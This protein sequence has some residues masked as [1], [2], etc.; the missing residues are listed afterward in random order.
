MVKVLIY[1]AGAIGSFLAYLL[2][3]GDEVN[4]AVDD[5][6]LLGRPG[7]MQE[8]GES[9]LQIKSSEGIKTIYFRHCFSQLNELSSS[10]FFPEVVVLCVKTH[11]LAAVSQEIEQSGLAGG[12]LK[13][14]EFILLMNGMGNRERIDLPS[15]QVFEGI[16]SIGVV[17]SEGGKIELKGRGK[18]IIESGIS[19]E[20]RQL[21]QERFAEKGF[22]IEF[23]EN[24]RAQQWN[25]LFANAVINPIT[26]LTGKR[27]E[28]I[29]CQDLRK[30]VE[31]VVEEC[32][33]AAALEGQRFD[34]GQVLDF[35]YSVASKTSSNISS[36]L[37]DVQKGNKTEI[38]S[39][40]GYIDR[41]GEKHGLK[42][43]VNRTLY[44]L[45]KAREK[46]K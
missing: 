6:A 23:A 14:A 31:G 33:A 15:D 13:R 38:D 18:T 19:P 24:F 44:Q 27:N 32:V 34:A 28:V 30:T 40:N 22:E 8:I 35:V 21:F 16:T 17:F 29:L 43:P 10:S 26:A 7:H 11:S 45:V 2:S 42:V 37:Q 41:L 20:T 4:H 39:I 3:S 25:K 9:G 1:G 5:V 36:M 12:R 46:R